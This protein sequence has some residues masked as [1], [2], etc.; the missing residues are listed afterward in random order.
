MDVDIKHDGALKVGRI[1]VC[2]ITFRQTI[3]CKR[4]HWNLKISYRL[5]LPTLAPIQMQNP[6][7]EPGADPDPDTDPD[8]KA[9]KY[10]NIKL[11]T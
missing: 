3:R 8:T 2:R 1:T 4:I 6:D 11:W 7:A 10:V 9:I 5:G